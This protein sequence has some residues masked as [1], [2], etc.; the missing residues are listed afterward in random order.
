MQLWFF[1]KHNYWNRHIE[2]PLCLDDLLSERDQQL[3]VEFSLLFNNFLIFATESS[4]LCSFPINCKPICLFYFFNCLL[5]VKSGNL[6]LMEKVFING[7][8]MFRSLCW[9]GKFFSRNLF[10]K[11]DRNLAVSLLNLLLNGPLLQL[12]IN[13]RMKFIHYCIVLVSLPWSSLSSLRSVK[14]GSDFSC[15]NIDIL[16]KQCNQ[17]LSSSQKYWVE[18]TINWELTGC[19][20]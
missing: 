19:S 6:V 1:L 3:F 5:L 7:I 4:T 14:I 13:S 18:T 16:F 9:R 17:F 8:N 12:W 10:T 2:D 11:R 20:G 15:H